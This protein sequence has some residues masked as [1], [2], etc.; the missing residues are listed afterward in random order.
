MEAHSWETS[1]YA[2]QSF[3]GAFNRNV[4]ACSD[5]KSDSGLEL[6]KSPFTGP[7]VT[8]AHL[9]EKP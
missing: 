3:R 6:W 7:W 8:A 5:S 2:L 4:S 1:R 9:M